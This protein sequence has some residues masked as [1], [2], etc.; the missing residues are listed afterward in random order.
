MKSIELFT[1]IIRILAFYATYYFMIDYLVICNVPTKVGIGTAITGVIILSTFYM[2][3]R[4]PYLKPCS[5][6]AHMSTKN[7]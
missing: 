7:Q 3:G 4:A 5:R 6:C 2:F 1:F